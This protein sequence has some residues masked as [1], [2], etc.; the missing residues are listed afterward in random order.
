M[1]VWE[2]GGMGIWR[3]GNMEVWEHGGVGTWR[4]WN[5]EVVMTLG[6]SADMWAVLEG[7]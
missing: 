3:Q 1:K 5:M 2:H 6:G 4:Y 7:V